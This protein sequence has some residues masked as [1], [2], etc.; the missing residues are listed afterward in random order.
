MSMRFLV[1]AF[2]LTFVLAVAHFVHADDVIEFNRDIRPILAANCFD[3]H[4]FDAKTRKAELRLDTAD[5]AY[6]D[7]DGSTAIKPG[8]LAGSSLWERVTSDDPEVVMPPPV[9]KKKPLTDEQKLVLRTW[10][11]QGAKY[12]NHWA[13]EPPIANAIPKVADQNGIR[14]PV[15]AFIR[16]KLETQGL[17]YS[18]EADRET[19]IRRVSFTLTGLPPTIPEIRQYVADMSDQ[20]Y[21][22]MV[23]RYLVSPHFGE[24]QARYWLDVARYAD[25]HGLHLDNER[26]MFA[27]RDWIVSAFN[28]NLPFDQFTRWQLAGDLLPEP[29][30]EQLVATGFNRCNVTTSEGGA[31]ADEWLYRYAVDRT[32]TTMQ[33]WMGLTAGCAVCHDHKFDPVTQKDFYSMYAFF[34]SATDPAMDGNVRNTNP[35]IKVPNAEQNA[36]LLAAKTAEETARTQ[37]EAAIATIEYQDPAA[38]AESLQPANREISDVVFDDAL[39]RGAKERNTSRDGVTW[40]LEPEFGAKSGRRVLELAFGSQYELTLDLPLI[41]VMVPHEGKIEFWLRVDPFAS[42]AAFALRIDD[43]R[44]RRAVWGDTEQLQIDKAEVEMGPLPTAGEWTHVVVPLESDVAKPEARIKS[45]VLTHSG[46]RIWIDDFR[47]SGK[48][49]AV[50][51]PLS[52]F[53]QWWTLSKA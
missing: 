46:G 47:I 13:F 7:H 50:T 21:E 20:A 3:C 12:Q 51:D 17:T 42:P 48:S 4:G 19:L 22:G 53:Q 41:P 24:E 44:N 33:A 36:E 26:Q 14:N 43:G 5:G 25:T 11:E 8:E 34:Y 37:L 29:T 10:I 35:F 16:E 49:S 28:Q 1:H 9:S 40:L 30:L 2:I 23:D 45:L 18:Q 6:A 39:P 15:D 52:S 31:I 27:Y 38:G 32:S